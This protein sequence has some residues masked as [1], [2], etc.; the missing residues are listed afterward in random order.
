MQWDYSYFFPS[1]ISANHVTNWGDQPMKYKIDVACMGKLGFDVNFSHLNEKDQLFCSQAVSCYN[2]FKDIVWHGDLFRL[3]NPHKN[4][5][6]SLMYVDQNKSK[7]IVFNYLVNS[8]YNAN[9]NEQPIKLNGLVANKNYTVKEINLYP[10]TKS[11]IQSD[12]IYSGDFLMKVG[13]NP[14]INSGR[15][16]VILE[17]NE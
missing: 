13:I 9:T 16:S 17:I 7:A 12:K 11:P 6:A 15:L 4:A 8:R 2:T 14:E 5:I 3:V 10:N 1:I